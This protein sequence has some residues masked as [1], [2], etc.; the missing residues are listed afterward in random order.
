VAVIAHAQ[1]GAIIAAQQVATGL[2]TGGT[3]FSTKNFYTDHM[4][5]VG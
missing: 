5:Q 4:T 2:L 3:P 1:E